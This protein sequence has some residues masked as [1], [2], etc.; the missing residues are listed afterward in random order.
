MSMRSWIRSLLTRPATRTIRKAPHPARLS[1]EALEDRLVPS[2]STYGDALNSGALSITQAAAGSDNLTLSLSNVNNTL[3]YTLTDTKGL[4]FAT[5]TGNW[6]ADIKGGGTS[7]ITVPSADVTSISVVLGSGTNVFS[8]TG[9]NGASAAPI[10]VN[11]GTTTN[12]QINITGAVLDSGAVSLTAATVNI[13]ASGSLTGT[14][15]INGNLVN[16]GQIGSATTPGILTVGGNFTQSSSGTLNE[17][18]GGATPGTGY[19]QLKVSG[20]A[21]LGGT[22][23]VSL[24]NGFQPGIATNDPV[25]TCSTRNGTSFASMTGLNLYLAAQFNDSASPNNLSLISGLAGVTFTVNNSNDYAIAGETSLRQAI[26]LAN[27]TTGP[28]TI[29]FD[30]SVFATAQTITLN[31][32]PLTLTNTATTTITGP[33]AGVTISG[34]NASQVFNINAGAAAALSGLTITGGNA[35]ATGNG[36]GLSNLGTTTLT[37]CTVSGNSGQWGGGVYGSTGSTT[38]LTN[39]TVSGNSAVYGGGLNSHGALTLNYCAVSN[40]LASSCGGGLENFNGTTT[41]TDST[42]SGNK[43]SNEYGGGLFCLG[44]QTTLTNCTVSGNQAGESGGGMYNRGAVTL[45]DCT[46]SGNVA[47]RRGGG[48][49][50]TQGTTTLTNCTI[51]GNS[52]TTNGGGINSNFSS[53]TTL[54]DCTVSGNFTSGSGGGLSIITGTISLGN[55]I[56][57]GNTAAY[58]DPDVFGTFASQGNNLI[59]MI[60]GSS[61]WV[62]SGPNADLTGTIAAPLNPLLAPLGNYGGPTQTMALLPGS[63]AID[64]GSN[65][66]IPSGVT[67]DQSG[68]ARTVNGTVDIGAFEFTGPQLP[69]APTGLAASAGLTSVSLSWNP[70]SGANS[71]NIY[72]GTSSGGESFV[73]SVTVASFNDTSLTSY[74]TYYYEVSAV[75]SSGEGPLSTEVSTTPG[76]DWF[77]NNMPDSGLQTLAGND[78]KQDGTINYNDMLG[79]LAQA[80]T[81]TGTGTMSSAVVASLQAIASSSGAAYLNMP[82]PL[83]GLAQNLIDGGQYQVT[84]AL[85]ANTTTAAQLQDLIN[86]WFLG[87]DLPT[88]DTQ[89]WSTSGY[90]LANAGTLFGSSGVPQYTDIYQG[91][92]GDCWLMA[93][94]AEIALKQPGIIQGSFTDDGLQN[95]ANVWTYEY[96]NGATP[97][98]LTV[99]NYFPSQSGK[100]MYADDGQTIANTSNVLWAPLMEKAYATIFAGAYASLDGGWAQNILPMET[101]GSC[102]NNNPFGSE[103]TYIAAIQS[104][105][106]LLTLGSNSTNYG[107]VA[108]H[109][110]AVL[111]VTGSGSSALFQLFNPWGLG[112]HQPPAIT[113]AQL[114][115]TGDFTQDGDTIVGA[116]AATGL[117]SGEPA[118]SGPGL[119]LA[120]I[121]SPNV[122]GAPCF[123][124]QLQAPLSSDSLAAYFGAFA[125]QLTASPPHRGGD[126]AGLTSDGPL[127]GDKP[128][129]APHSQLAASIAAS[130]DS[131]FW[132]SY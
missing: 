100:F 24:L 6:K 77:A 72:R 102:A 127:T 28:E 90:V 65:L 34:N 45:V 96:Y 59:G 17:A 58:S 10:T 40:N 92:E 71:Y 16:A 51:S 8:F 119:Y 98:Y 54:T 22:L 82:A 132:A 131:Q 103:S 20:T 78:F 44:G 74:T 63:P 38:T 3:I 43:A 29:T 112:N 126:D 50:D 80:V 113:W 4:K 121:F 94:F 104:P 91:E 76:S 124:P 39:C 19:G 93:S 9:T 5:P 106:T 32:G 86:Q 101:G 37:N 13:S 117:R 87:E 14:G 2:I 81:E 64:A 85:S 79:L 31:A 67:T 18:V 60:D 46:V 73:T 111:S 57:T 27:L 41:L 62:T 61:G 26:A 114:T 35:G 95:G 122:G 130:L 30:P 110:Y 56:V 107:F 108:N 36:G 66:L 123:A 115:Q 125:P 12:D 55:T 11:T 89:A 23:N 109:D 70:V 84:T 97:E 15:N 105:T 33:A 25:L 68:S 120:D 118:A 83:A 42:V 69:P 52:A 128:D 129:A 116:A 47:H 49:S 21:T 1:L 88:I 75:N 7:T 48:L 53:V 99:N